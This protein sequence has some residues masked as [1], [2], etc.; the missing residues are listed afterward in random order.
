M[1]FNVVPNLP[2]PWS[3]ILALIETEAAGSMV[4]VP[5]GMITVA[6]P[7]L[8]LA[9]EARAAFSAAESSVTPSHTIPVAKTG[10]IST[11][12]LISES[13]LRSGA[14]RADLGGA[15]PYALPKQ[16]R[17]MLTAENAKLR[18]RN[19]LDSMIFAKLN[20]FT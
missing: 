5:G 17:K 11:L 9:A 16:L 18:I 6:L 13:V 7:N 4:H 15:C 10:F 2:A 8:G 12:A 3:Q 20:P 14:V 19:L 1:R